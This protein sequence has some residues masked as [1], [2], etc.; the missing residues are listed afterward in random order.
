MAVDQSN[1]TSVMFDAES[2]PEVFMFVT[3]KIYLGFIGRRGELVSRDQGCKS[4]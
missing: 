1:G 3:N 4:G 2:L